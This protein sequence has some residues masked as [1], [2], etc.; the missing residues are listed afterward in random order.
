MNRIIKGIDASPG[1][2]IGKV[3]LYAEQELEINKGKKED[4]EKEKERLLSGREKTKDQL[5]II[6]EKTA[7]K[8]GEDKAAIFDGHITLLEDED[9]FDEVVELIEDENISAEYAL[10]Q[11]IEGY[12]E[13]LANLDDE[14]LRERAT[15]L[16]DIAKRWLN[17]IAGIV[18]VDLSSLPENTVVVAKD[19]TPSDTAQLDLQNVVAFITE[20]GGKTAHSSIM[21]RSLEL[22]A[23]VGTGNACSILKNGD[24]VAVDALKGEVI[25]NPTEEEKNIYAEKRAQYFEERELLKQLKDQEAISKDGIKVGAWANI[26]DPKDVA[27]VLRNG[28]QGIGLYRTEFLFMNND[29]F[30]TEDEQFE[31][32]KSVAESMQGKPV[33]IRTMD[34]G[35]DK[36]LP[37]M[38]LPKEENPFLGWRALRVCLDRPEILKTQFRALLRA[39][40]YGY[41]KIML[42]MI[43]SLEE[44][45]K[46]KE[47]LEECK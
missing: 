35:G 15:D 16:R 37:Y 18:A 44:I 47:I 8:L 3:Y 10:S 33:T 4:T 23:I 46:S 41:I 20:I 19:L 5:V 13:M 12:C 21:A 43:I 39:S 32:Y 14:Y 26:G 22:P 24:T 42:P 34:I 2:A 25:I 6:R 1:I 45:R 28:G 9:L 36:C 38:Q 7:K 27:G 17:N 40:A 31:A 11:G 29:R 30:P